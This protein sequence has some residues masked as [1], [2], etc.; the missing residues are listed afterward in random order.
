MAV[1]TT[2]EDEFETLPP[3]IRRK[4][5]STLERLRLAHG[6]AGHP[7]AGLQSHASST[8]SGSRHG[9]R[10]P[11]LTA[12]R[13]SSRRLQRN[14]SRNPSVIGQPDAQF[15]LALPSKVKSRH[16]SYEER[17]LL[18]GKCESIIL[19]PADEAFYRAGRQDTP[20]LATLDSM[21]TTSSSSLNS[22]RDKAILNSVDMS[23]ALNDS[24][25]WLDEDEELDLSL[26]LDEYHAH[27]VADNNAPPLPAN[28]HSRK[29]S[30]RRAALYATRTFGRGSTSSAPPVKAPQQ[31]QQVQ[32]NLSRRTSRS[33]VPAGP[34]HSNRESISAI[35]PEAK[36]YQDPE[37]RLK[38]RVYL[39]SPQKFDEAIE[40]GFPSDEGHIRGPGS[41]RRPTLESRLSEYETQTFLDDNVSMF[42]D[43]SDGSMP[44]IDLPLTPNDA[45]AS[46]RLSDKL[47][48]KSGSA[49][50]NTPSAR[51][52][53]ADS[54]AHAWAGSREM[55]LRM[56]LTRPDLRADESVLYGWQDRPKND[57]LA[58]DELP[59]AADQE[60]PS[61]VP[62]PFGGSDGWGGSERRGVVKKIWKKVKPDFG[63]KRA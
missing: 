35:D 50:S 3:A 15:W 16:F 8:S 2:T 21:S 58:L 41:Q 43:A 14:R 19:D 26:G 42:E 22:A 57:P 24:F 18:E 4:Y 44:D 12:K 25:R 61:A 46:F 13:D 37:A 55:T 53:L 32:S 39:A 6:S 29:P 60:A 30:F 28:G 17:L 1:G 38:L 31:P 62:G 45:D 59:P 52:R 34:G 48:S 5:F 10:R 9:S 36:Y 11:S 33:I 51:P 47:P 54:Y 56:T 63:A 49:G 27:L 20:S 40:F 23:D 7:H